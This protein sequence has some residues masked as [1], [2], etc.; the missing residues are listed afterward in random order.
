MTRRRSCAKRLS[1]E[2]DAARPPLVFVSYSQKDKRHLERL[3]TF[4]KCKHREG[5][6]DAWDDSRIKPGALWRDEIEAALD[7][8]CLFIVLISAD[9]LASD[10]IHRVELP[11]LL[12]NH[13]DRGS[14]VLTVYVGTCPDDPSLSKFQ[15]VNSPKTPL[16]RMTPDQRDEVWTRL[17]NRIDE[18]VGA[19]GGTG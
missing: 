17:V 7:S 11:R 4:L 8:A 6:I 13:A 2:T 10:F 18:L 15:A 16:N 19:S 5:L 1:A 14:H 9:F 12:A 3:R